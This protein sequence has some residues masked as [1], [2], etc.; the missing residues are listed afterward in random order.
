MRRSQLGESANERTVKR[1]VSQLLSDSAFPALI[2]AVAVS[3]VKIG[4]NKED[5]P[6]QRGRQSS[7]VQVDNRFQLSAGKYGSLATTEY[8]RIR[9]R[10]EPDK[11]SADD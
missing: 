11:K 8:S 7:G 4:Q 5:A 6:R 3:Q 9:E 1:W 10:T 2:L